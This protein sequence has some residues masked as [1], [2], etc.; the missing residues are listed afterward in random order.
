MVKWVD[1]S[2]IPNHFVVPITY[3]LLYRTVTYVII[4]HIIDLIKKFPTHD[5]GGISPSRN[6]V[7]NKVFGCFEGKEVSEKIA[8]GF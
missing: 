5:I 1:T 8:G 3:I 4:D 6:D 7:S 2:N